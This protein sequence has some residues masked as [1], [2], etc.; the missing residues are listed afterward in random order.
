[1]FGTLQKKQEGGVG[2][3]LKKFKSK[4]VD[5][6]LATGEFRY[7][8]KSGAKVSI[9]FFRVRTNLK[10]YDCDQDIEEIYVKH[11]K[12]DPNSP[13][14][15]P[16]SFSFKCRK[17]DFTFTCRTLEE[18]DQWLSCFDMLLEFRKKLQQQAKE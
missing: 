12:E 1:M 10:Q 2:K 18:R 4:H 7:M 3:L 13:K 9:I 6:S 5:L 15:F 8:N 11:L 16:Y 17:R 14:E